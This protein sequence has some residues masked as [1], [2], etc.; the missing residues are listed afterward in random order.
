MDGAIIAMTLWFSGDQIAYFHLGASS[1]LGYGVSASYALIAA[2]IEEYHDCDI[3]NLGGVAGLADDNSGLA[4][5]KRGFANSIAYSHLCGMVL[6]Q[7]AYAAM[8]ATDK[9]GEFFPVYRS[10][11][12]GERSA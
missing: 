6:N 5:F 1:A 2:A 4:R 8:A 7:Q 12:Q 11:N 9:E 10:P 3:V